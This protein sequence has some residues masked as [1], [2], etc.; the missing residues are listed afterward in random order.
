MGVAARKTTIAV[1][2]GSRARR[3][4]WPAG[5]P[6]QAIGVAAPSSRVGSEKSTQPTNHSAA[7]MT[8]PSRASRAVPAARGDDPGQPEQTG[9]PK[10]SPLSAVPT[11]TTVA[12]PVRCPCSWAR[13]SVALSAATDPGQQA[14]ER[15]QSTSGEQQ[16]GLPTCSVPAPDLRRRERGSQI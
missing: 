2:P 1:E 10:A 16:V 12:Q 11:A 15:D 13:R 8:N 5:S 4:P 9:A 6:A 3:S 7:A 14:E